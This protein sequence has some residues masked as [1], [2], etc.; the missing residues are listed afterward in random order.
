VTVEGEKWTS[1][2]FESIDN[3][4]VES[5]TAFL[6]EDVLFRFGNTEPVTGKAAVSDAV[7]GFF[8]SIQSIQ[9]NMIAIWDEESEVICHGT[10]TY[11]RHD[12]TTLRVPFALIL[13]VDN[14]LIKQYLIFVD[15]SQLYGGC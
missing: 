1:L 12:S 13:S 7:K 5:F 11:T 2:L 3:Q 10:V 8:A 9:H 15:V 14:D 6:A 4:D